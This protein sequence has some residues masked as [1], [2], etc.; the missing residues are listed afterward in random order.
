[1]IEEGERHPVVLD[2]RLNVVSLVATALW[3]P[4]VT[5][6]VAYLGLLGNPLV[7]LILVSCWFGSALVFLYPS[8]L[9]IDDSEVV[10]T[11]VSGQSKRWPRESLELAP[12]WSLP[13][14]A[15]GA[16]QARSNGKTAFIIWSLMSDSSLALQRLGEKVAVTNQ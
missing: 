9:K 6:F 10:G 2:V 3:M 14:S 15:F 12:A 16:R 11:W 1:M 5:A 4:I 7:I 8:A 13:S